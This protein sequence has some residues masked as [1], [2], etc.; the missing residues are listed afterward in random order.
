VLD[1]GADVVAQHPADACAARSPD[2]PFLDSMRDAWHAALALARAEDPQLPAVDGRW[3]AVGGD[4]R[5]FPVRLTGRSASGAAARGWYYALRKK[6][7]DE[8]VIVIAQVR[9]T[10]HDLAKGKFELAGVDA[11]GVA[12]KVRAIVDA[13]RFDTVV[14][15]KGNDT[16]A[17]RSVMGAHSIRIVVLSSEDP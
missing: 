10:S 11:K 2:D 14:I 5:P 7:P 16:D 12:P 15:A 4:G 17:L 8:G 13:K 9:P 6:I 3:R 1:G